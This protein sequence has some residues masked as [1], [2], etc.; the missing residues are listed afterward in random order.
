MLREH[1]LGNSPL[2]FNICILHFSRCY[3]RLLISSPQFRRRIKSKSSIARTG[4]RLTLERAMNSLSF[5]PSSEVRTTG[6]PRSRR[7]ARHGKRG[8]RIPWSLRLARHGKQGFRGPDDGI[9]WSRGRAR[10]GKQGFRC[11]EA[12]PAPPEA[13]SAPPDCPRVPY[14]SKTLVEIEKQTTRHRNILFSKRK[15]PKYMVVY[16]GFYFL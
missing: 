14:W 8:F 5:I 13:M 1:T 16:G 7:H 11:P 3:W 12:M 10:H 6:F 2:L 9:P 4:W 15:L